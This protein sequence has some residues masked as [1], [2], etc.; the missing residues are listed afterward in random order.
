MNSRSIF[1]QNVKLEIGFAR[2][3]INSQFLGLH[4]SGHQKVKFKS[5]QKNKKIKNYRGVLP[6][7]EPGASRTLSENHTTRPQDQDMIENWP[8]WSSVKKGSVEWQNRHVLV[9]LWYQDQD[10]FSKLC[11]LMFV[12]FVFF[13][14][15]FFKAKYLVLMWLDFTT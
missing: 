13:F 6:G 12:V 11:L 1:C 3:H 5:S 2:F 7:L 4:K 8:D 14:F 9:L 15:F 10:R